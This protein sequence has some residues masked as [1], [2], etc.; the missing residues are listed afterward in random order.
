MSYFVLDSP[1]DIARYSEKWVKLLTKSSCHQTFSSPQ[2]FL[3]TVHAFPELSPNVIVIERQGEVIAIAPCVINAERQLMFVSDLADYQDIIIKQNDLVAAKELFESLVSEG[4]RVASIKLSGL[5]PDANLHLVLEHWDEPRVNPIE[6][7]YFSDL[8]DGYEA[9]MESKS[10]SFRSNL[11]RL[12]R[13][14]NEKGIQIC[15]LTPSDCSGD[16]IVTS[17]LRL[18]LKRFP[19]KLFSR[20][21]PQFF[22]RLNLTEQFERSLLRVFALI[23]QTLEGNQIKDKVVALNLTVCD[24]SVLGIWNSGFDPKY[25]NISPGKLLIH[26]Q[27]QTCCEEGFIE[28][29]F[30]RGDEAYKQDWSTSSR[31]LSE[32]N[33]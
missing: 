16:D 32:F 2:W 19:D 23:D 7:C 10:A 14:A 6:H 8:S 12:H 27:I 9:F 11:R 13:R 17:F 22:C 24:T 20:D 29:D 25:S 30:L 18:H 33:A 21:K 31:M 5:S 28:F 4:Q 3:N 15:E 26:K 1:S